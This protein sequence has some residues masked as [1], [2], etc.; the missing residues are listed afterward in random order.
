MDD[1]KKRATAFAFRSLSSRK[2]NYFHIQE[3]LI[4]RIIWVG[5]DL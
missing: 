4:H 2:S 5:R 3:A 1:G